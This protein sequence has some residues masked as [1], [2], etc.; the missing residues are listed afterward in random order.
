MSLALGGLAGPGSMTIPQVL[1][2]E[3]I[4]RNEER[5]KSVLMFEAMS[6]ARA[7]KQETVDEFIRS[8]RQC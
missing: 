6:I 8:K 3:K 2:L 7:E 4:R 5:A 1:M